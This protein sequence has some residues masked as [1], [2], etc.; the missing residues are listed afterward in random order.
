MAKS[1]LQYWSYLIHLSE[2]MWGQPSIRLPEDT[3]PP[4]KL[5]TDDGTWRKVVDFLPTQGFNTVVID[6]GDGIEYETHPEIS[7]SGAWSKDK[8]KTELEHIRSLGMKPIPKLN[9][10]TGHDGWLGKYAQMISTPEYYQVCKD[11]I[12]EV[13]ELFDTPELFHLGMDEETAANQKNYRLVRVRGG[14]LFWHDLN[15]MFGVCEKAGSRPWIWAD[16]C[17]RDPKDF[18]AH[19]SKCAVQSN[20]F[21]GYFKKNPDGSYNEKDVEVYRTLEKAGYDQIPTCSTIF[22]N[23][24]CAQDIMQLGKDDISPEHLLGYISTPWFMTTPSDL[25]A[26]LN[27]AQR[28]GDAK[29]KIYPETV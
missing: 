1:K 17:C 24:K 4:V 28:F 25:Y 20:W 19:M 7:V 11:L 12:L 10:S 23:W 13:A 14:D 3:D 5:N 27:E 9:F 21:Y 6:V 22:G 18:L 26:L 8:L 16:H 2:N 29:R 15:Y